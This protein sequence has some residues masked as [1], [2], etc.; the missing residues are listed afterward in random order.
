MGME[1]L[2]S[3]FNVVPTADAV[4]VSLRDA[5]SVTFIGVGT[6]TFTVESA[7]DAGGTGAASLSV[8]THY[9]RNTSAAGAAAWTEVTQAVAAT[10]S[11]TSSGI[12]AAYVNANSLPAGADYVRCSSAGAGL[13]IAILHDLSVQRSPVNLPAAAV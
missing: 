11:A 2:G 12:A 6:D 5:Q 9:Y 1:G 10:F 8:L 13:V 3:A 7:T 4:E